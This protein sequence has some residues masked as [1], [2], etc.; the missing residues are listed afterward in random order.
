M[1]RVLILIDKYHIYL[2]YFY[3]YGPNGSVIC[4]GYYLNIDGIHIGFG[5]SE[6]EALED[7]VKKQID[8]LI[9]LYKIGAIEKFITEN[10]C[11]YFFTEE[12][13]LRTE[14]LIQECR[15]YNP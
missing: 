6:K 11:G 14:Q 5:N 13:E 7:L 9:R 10:R 8:V 1:Q 15:N 2:N 3:R 12:E 4:K